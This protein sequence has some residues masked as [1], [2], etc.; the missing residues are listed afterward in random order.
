MRDALSLT[1]EQHEILVGGLLG[2]SYLFPTVSGKY[3]SMRVAHGPK[4]RDYVWWKYEF[5]KQWVLS[6]PKYQLQNK[7]MITQEAWTKSVSALL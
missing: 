1:A 3:A 6:P 7:N 5:F 4:Q 2:D